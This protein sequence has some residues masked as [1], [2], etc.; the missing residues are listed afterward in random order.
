MWSKKYKM[1]S[2]CGTVNL[3]HG[4]FLISIYIYIYVFVK[5]KTFNKHTMNKKKK[6]CGTVEL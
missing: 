2:E 5:E 3:P 4:P 1:P 6:E